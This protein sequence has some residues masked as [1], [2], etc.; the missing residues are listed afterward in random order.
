MRHALR[1]CLLAALLCAPPAA[2]DE[3]TGEEVLLDGIAAQVG[4]DIVLVSEV[5]ELSRPREKAMLARGATKQQIAQARADSLETVIEW[6][7]IEQ[8]V[9]Q[10]ELYATDAE[11]DTTIEAIAQEN[12][13]TME[14]LRRQVLGQG[15][16]WESYR[17]EIK[18]ELE[19]R[20]IVNAMVA[21][22]ITIEDSELESVYAEHF[23]DQPDSGATVH[24]RQILTV[25]GEAD[26]NRSVEEACDLVRR[27]RASITTGRDFSDFATRYSVVAPERG[28][29]L[30][31]MHT[32]ELAGYLEE[33]VAELEP[34]QLSPV[35]ELPV[36]C[37][38]VQLVE[39]REFKPISFE[40]A[41]PRLREE[42]FEQKM[43]TEY[44][45]WMEE[46]RE[47][48]FIE[49]RGYFADAADFEKT[50]PQGS[51][52]EAGMSDYDVFGRR[53]EG[54]GDVATP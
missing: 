51:E 1:I 36:G 33:L 11:I 14:Q 42:L 28:G 50:A 32:D 30:G 23:A 9:R 13:L 37:T 48:T 12:G 29:D 49:R 26:P 2:A 20:K 41:K 16:G 22:Q 6:R 47:R 38:L 40:Q 53:R 7:L 54:E 18:R 21:A 17:Q 3:A 39:R 15:M 10:T 27:A 25:G 46:M 45:D 8:M 4:S 34:G 43:M 5:M 44:R 19:R 52:F 24:L 31:W 35:H